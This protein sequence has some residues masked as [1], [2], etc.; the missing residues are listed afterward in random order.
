MS[1]LRRFIRRVMEWFDADP[2][3]DAHRDWVLR[4][5]ALDKEVR[6]ICGVKE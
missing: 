4:R 2:I 3:A 5:I 1:R 6:R